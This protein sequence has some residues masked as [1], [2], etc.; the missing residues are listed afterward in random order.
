MQFAEE[1]RSKIIGQ[2]DLTQ[3]FW[4]WL[5]PIDGLTEDFP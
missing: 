5:E 3:G 2:A 4:V 1:R